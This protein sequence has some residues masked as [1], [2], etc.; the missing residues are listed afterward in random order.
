MVWN[1]FKVDSFTFKCPNII[2]NSHEKNDVS[3]NSEKNNCAGVS[4][5]LE[6]CNFIKKDSNTV[7]FLWIIVKFLRAGFLKKHLRL[8]FSHYY[9]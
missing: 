2:R 4:C 6:A 9:Q 1:M 5:Q 3:Q 8:L 7:F